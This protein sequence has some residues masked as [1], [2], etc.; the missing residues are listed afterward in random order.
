MW[1]VSV[2]CC[3]WACTHSD[4]GQ[5]CKYMLMWRVCTMRAA[6]QDMCC[7]CGGPPCAYNPKPCIPKPYIP[8]SQK[9]KPDTLNL[10]HQSPE[11]RPK[12]EPLKP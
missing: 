12:P 3:V 4:P 8:F 6:G 1:F 9:P 7:L 2:R 5:A 10:I 11:W